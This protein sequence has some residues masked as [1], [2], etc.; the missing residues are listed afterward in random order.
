MS[1]VT[2]NVSEQM[3]G[4]WDRCKH[5]V[6]GTEIWRHEVGFLGSTYWYVIHLDMPDAPED[7]DTVVLVWRRM[8]DGEPVLQDCI[9]RDMDGKLITTERLD[10]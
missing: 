6:P 3:L 2:T 10:A 4:S 1:I 8:A 5:L 7:A 9:W